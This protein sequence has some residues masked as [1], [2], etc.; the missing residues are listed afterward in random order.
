LTFYKPGKSNLKNKIRI[1][2]QDFCFYTFMFVF[3]WLQNGNYIQHQTQKTAKLR[4]KRQF[5]KIADFSQKR[6]YIKPG[7]PVYKRK[8]PKS[9]EFRHFVDDAG[10]EPATR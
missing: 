5:Y 2:T 7:P 10:V 6:Q 3:K 8:M 1:S 4:K 9:C